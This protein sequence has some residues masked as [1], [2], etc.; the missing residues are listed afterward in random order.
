M[1]VTK[2]RA[3]SS[4]PSPQFISSFAVLWRRWLCQKMFR[5]IVQIV[6]VP[7][8]AKAEIISAFPDNHSRIGRLMHCMIANTDADR[9]FRTVA[10]VASPNRI[11]DGLCERAIGGRRR[12]KEYA[13]RR[14]VE[15]HVEPSIEEK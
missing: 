3:E 6:S 4:R 1:F 12:G 2:Q 7:K 9:S 14:P 10:N 5:Y 13:G 11:L 8:L 15:R